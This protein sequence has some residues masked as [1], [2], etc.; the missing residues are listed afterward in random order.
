MKKETP[1]NKYHKAVLYAI[2]GLFLMPLLPKIAGNLI[3]GVFII[4]SIVAYFNTLKRQFNWKFFIVISLLY[5]SYIGSLFYSE[6]MEYALRKLSTA[7]PLILFPLSLSLFSSSLV[8]LVKK[9]TKNYIKVY[10]GSIVL[11]SLIVIVD[12]FKVIHDLE[13]F[14]DQILDKGTVVGMDALYLSLHIALALIATVYLY[15]LS[16][17]VWKAI[18]AILTISILFVL[19]LILSFKSAIISFTVAFGLYALM[20]NKTKLW[21]LFMS[22]TVLVIGLLTFSS[23]FNENFNRLLIVKDSA[24]MEYAEIKKTIQ[25]CSIELIPEAGLLG[26]GLGDGKEELINCYDGKSSSLKNASYNSHNQYL[27][28]FLNVGLFGLILFAFSLFALLSTGLNHR[29]YLGIAILVLF[30]VFML[31]ENVLERQQGVVYFA[32]FLNLLFIG[33]FKRPVLKPLILSHEKVLES[34]N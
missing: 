6:N 18:V 17:K 29:N 23:S 21:A 19:L 20:V 9:E 13:L 31:A 24:N 11:L 27:S 25:S 10:V 22:A 14:H 12:N 2:Y 32:L 30:G 34:L 3:I 26:F 1:I 16:Q 8:E 5:F 7:S 4:V 33:N 28:I 15:F